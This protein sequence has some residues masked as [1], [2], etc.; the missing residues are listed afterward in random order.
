L[1]WQIK[2]VYSSNTDEANPNLIFRL[3]IKY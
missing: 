1:K 2:G 3:R